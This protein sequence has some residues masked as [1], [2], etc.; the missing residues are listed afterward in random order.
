MSKP[1]NPETAMAYELKLYSP[2]SAANGATDVAYTGYIVVEN[3]A[4]DLG[5]EGGRFMVRCARV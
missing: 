5:G 3:N 4:E 1:T 2:S